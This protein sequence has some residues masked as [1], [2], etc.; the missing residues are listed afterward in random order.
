MHSPKNEKSTFALLRCRII[1]RAST[2][3][4][5]AFH[6]DLFSFSVEEQWDGKV[7]SNIRSGNDLLS[8]K[9][10]LGPVD[11]IQ[12]LELELCACLDEFLLLDLIVTSVTMAK[13]KVSRVRCVMTCCTNQSILMEYRFFRVQVMLLLFYISSVDYNELVQC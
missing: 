4:I 9:F 12:L 11:L 13:L 10:S 8:R 6:L 1:F 3:P 7:L 2:I 5:N